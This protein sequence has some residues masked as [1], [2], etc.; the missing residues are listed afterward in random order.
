MEFLI[1]LLQKAAES[2]LI[3]LSSRLAERLVAPSKKKKAEKKPT[4]RRTSKG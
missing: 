1:I 4:S 2:F 3:T